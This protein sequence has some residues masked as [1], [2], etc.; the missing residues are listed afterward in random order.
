MIIRDAGP[1]VHAIVHGHTNCFAIEDDDGITLVDACYPST[2]QRVEECLAKLGKTPAD[3]RGLVLTHGHFD[4][5]GF[6]SS[7]QRR[8]GVPVWAHPA[9][10]FICEHPYR[11]R[12]GRPRGLYPVAYPRA[13]PVLTGM[14]LAGALR[15]P[16]VSADHPLVDGATLALPGRPQVI[17][18]P[19]HT[20]GECVFW[21]PDRGVLLTGDALVTLDPYSGRRG[22]RMVSRAGTNDARRALASAHALA[23][24]DAQHVLPGHG[25]MWDAGV[26]A[27]VMTAAGAL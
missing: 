1:G 9:D 15:V 25:A 11:Y 5:L 26:E 6:A 13:I 20:D 22:P 3:I 18:T 17:S 4:H 16:G 12:P 10:F 27:A 14:V 2:W 8:F 19:G 24:I 21:L 23:A 7:I